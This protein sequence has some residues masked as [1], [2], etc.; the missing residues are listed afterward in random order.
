[1]AGSASIDFAGSP[2]G[3]LGQPGSARVSRALRSRLVATTR[4][5]R[6][7]SAARAIDGPATGGCPA[8]AASVVTVIRVSVITDYFFS[9]LDI[10]QGKE[11]EVAADQLQKAIGLT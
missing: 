7:Q 1:M 11:Y 9:R 5:M 2:F 6:G 3:T 10:S 8:G 4:R